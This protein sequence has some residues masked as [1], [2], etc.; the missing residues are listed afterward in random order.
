M[1]VIG[2]EVAA[3]SA[4]TFAV[5]GVDVKDMLRFGQ[6]EVKALMRASTPSAAQ[7][8]SPK[9]FMRRR[10]PERFSDSTHLKKIEINREQLEYHL[11][12]ITSR[13][14]EA[15]FERFARR[16]AEVE[17]CP[18]LIPQTGPTGGGDGKVDSDTHAVAAI[19][20]LSWYSGDPDAPRAAANGGRWALAVSAQ[21]RWKKKI[22]SDIEK[23]VKVRR[24]YVRAFFISNQYISSKQRHD[25]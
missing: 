20:T 25:L 17:I 14:Q 7:F 3:R 4:T 23:L 22:E 8:P 11:E 16:L 9:E 18:N 15:D 2:A 12:R 19:L 10:R 24:Q 6:R 1:V 5:T 13:N 21:R